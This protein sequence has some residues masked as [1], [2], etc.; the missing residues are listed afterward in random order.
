MG[1]IAMDQA[2]DIALG[3][4]ESSTSVHPS[5][6]FTGRVPTDAA[7]SLETEQMITAGTGSQTGGLSRWGDYSAMTLDPSDDCTFFY[8]QEYIKTDGSF[9]WN[10]HIATFKFAGCGNT[11]GSPAVTLSATTLSFRKT[12]IG[13]TSPAKKVTLTNTGTAT[14]HFT[15]VTI[16]GDFA[17]TTNTCGSQVSAGSNCVITMTFSPTAKGT[18]KSTLT[19]NDDAVGSP[20]TVALTGT[21]MSIAATPSSFN[22]GTV[23]VGTSSTHSF[24]VSNVGTTS[25]NLTGFTLTG[26]GIADYSITSNTCGATI[27][28]GGACSIGVKFAPSV[29]SKRNATLSVANNGGG[30]SS[31]VTLAGTGG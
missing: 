23:T 8:T 1:S 5:I 4:S 14:L 6:F 2:G 18:R 22:Y 26:T 27:A 31:A 11:A 9:N 16:G 21:G 17:I 24:V 25:V 13:Q 29:K 10:T 12:P 28:P 7:G 30:S 20:Q 19:F 3:Y 15:S